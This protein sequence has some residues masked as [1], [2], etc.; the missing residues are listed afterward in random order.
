MTIYIASVHSNS[1]KVQRF[2]NMEKIDIDDFWFILR[3]SYFMLPT[4]EDVRQFE[5]YIKEEWGGLTESVY[6]RYDMPYGCNSR[7]WYTVY[8]GRVVS[9]F[10]AQ[11]A[12]RKAHQ[13]LKTL[14]SFSWEDT[15]QLAPVVDAEV[16]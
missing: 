8:R 16:L 10:E 15:I 14:N 9:T 4:M 3:D 12:I 7:I 11:E 13:K 1:V 2:V 5:S 6:F